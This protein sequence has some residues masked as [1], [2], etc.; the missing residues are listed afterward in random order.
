MS[1]GQ[2]LDFLTYTNTN[3]AFN[4]KHHI[5][6]P[7]FTVIFNFNGKTSD[8][9]INRIANYL[10]DDLENFPNKNPYYPLRKA[11]LA[12][13]ETGV[14]FYHKLKADDPESYTFDDPASLNRISYDLLQL[15]KMPEAITVF[16][17]LVKEFPTVA[18]AYDSLGEGYFMNEQCEFSMTNYQ[19]SL[20]LNPEN[21]NAVTIMA[22]IAER[23]ELVR[24]MANSRPFLTNS[25]QNYRLLLVGFRA[26]STKLL[27]RLSEVA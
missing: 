3:H 19:K 16:E 10:Y 23:T 7:V 22:E 27:F 12:D 17:L 26:R 21:E 25:F 9:L 18:N 15:D 24:V 8:R 11:M 20:A 6:S 13:V 2:R 14:D 5:L 1:L 4:K